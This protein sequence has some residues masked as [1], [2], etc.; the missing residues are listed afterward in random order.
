M[1]DR[2]LTDTNNR[3]VLF[4]AGN[5]GRSAFA[6]LKAAG[7]Q[8]LAMADNNRV[9]WDT[10]V[11]GTPLLSPVETAERF[12]KDALFIVTILNEQHWYKGTYEQLGSL[13]CE[14]IV[15]A[16]P[17][18]WR[19]SERLLPF[20][21]Y[22]LPRK[23]YEQADR[24]LLAAQVWEDDASRYEY[25]A[26]I[27]LRALGEPFGLPRPTTESY[28][29]E[30][31]FD[32]SPG[33]RLLDC[34]AFDGDTIRTL[35]ARQPHF[36]FVEAI[37]ADSKSFHKLETYVAALDHSI[38]SR[39]RLDKCAIGATRGTVRFEDSG[40]SGFK[41]SGDGI[42]V[43]MVPIDELCAATRVTMIKMGIEGAEFD[44]LIGG[45]SVIQRDRP[46]LAICVYHSQED[47]W[48]LPC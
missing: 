9:L 37:E 5:L 11:D 41:I 42:E 14:R 6:A 4:G 20:L 8:S 16:A 34:G 39:I 17:V 19:F 28:F 48:R 3:C 23:L 18:C 2:L 30:G 15:S 43:E 27:R 24:V 12:G 46:V 45:K 38:Q 25:L 33:E 22:D 32:A 36:E 35:L 47:I 1:L 29:L 31:I 13:G 44:G 26:H 10:T 21:L 40:T 7:I